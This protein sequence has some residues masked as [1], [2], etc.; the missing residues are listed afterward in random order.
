MVDHFDLLAP[1]YDRLISPPDTTRLQ[2]L[3]RLPTAGWMLDAGGGTG[4]VTAQ[5]QP[6]VGRLVVSDLSRAMLSRA[7]SRDPLWPV[8]GRAE[9]LPFPEAHFD[10]VLVVDA[11]HHFAD[12]PAAIRELVRVLKPGGRL[13]IEEP[14]I[15]YPVV[16]LIALVE[17][18]TL[19]RSRF[20]PPEA[21][22]TMITACGLTPD[23]ERD[24]RFTAWV[25]ADR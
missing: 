2:V 6:L 16:R 15:R 1:I 3:L 24:G 17:K 9:R 4:R 25:T 13:V 19:M 23:I 5:L 18:L 10:R 21:I 8:Q 11:L 7:A 12:Q 20:H 14:D 22:G